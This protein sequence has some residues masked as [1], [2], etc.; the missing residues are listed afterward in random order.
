MNKKVSIAIMCYNQENFINETIESCL[1]QTYKNIEI[2]ISDDCSTDKTYEIILDYKSKYPD[3]IKCFQQKEN[4]WKHSLSINANSMLDL[5]TWDYIALLDGDDIMLPEKIQKQI[6]FLEE[7]PDCIW[8]STRSEAFI[9]NT[10]ESLWNIHYYLDTENR[11]TEKFI[12][13][14]NSIPP[15]ILFKNLKWLK[16]NTSLKIM[17]DW[18]FYTELSTHW[19]IWHLNE[20]LTKY[21]IHSNNSIWKDLWID[22]ILTLDIINNTYN[23]KYD[24]SVSKWKTVYYMSMWRKNILLKNY[25]LWLLLIF[26]AFISHP[27][28]FIQKAIFFLFYYK[29]YHGNESSN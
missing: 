14:W 23:L 22:Y 5:C 13:K 27:I 9:S 1:N 4:M 26:K 15:W 2:C 28:I 21:R 18:L 24:Y 19:K 25:F 12:S 7:N 16:Y 20:I 29:T 3:I 8:V 6:N 11:T 10:W 17:C